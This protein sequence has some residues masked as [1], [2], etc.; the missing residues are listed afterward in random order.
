MLLDRIRLSADEG[1]VD[2]EIAG[3][4]QPAIG[5]NDVPCRQAHHVARHELLDGDGLLPPIA[6]D[7]SAEADRLPQRLD[8][9][10]RPQL[11]H[12]VED[13]AQENDGG[14]DEEARRLPGPRREAGCEEQDEN[15][16]VREAMQDLPPKGPSATA[17]RVIG[18]VLSEAAYHF[19]GCKP[20]SSR[21]KLCK[22]RLRRNAPGCHAS[23]HGSAS[24]LQARSAYLELFA[25]L[26][27]LLF[28]LPLMQRKACWLCRPYK[29]E[30]RRCVSHGCVGGQSEPVRARRSCR[31]PCGSFFST[32]PY[33][34][35][36]KCSSWG[37]ALPQSRR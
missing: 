6:N 15:K 27:G 5:R 37:S 25:P 3:R 20:A 12:D 9:V 29:H 26:E 28:R 21:S 10:L 23:G 32:V 1:L 14:D 11:L 2:E 34:C 8:S 36:A 4:Q 19:L 13:N 35:N 22:K 16:R 18:S 24:W 7:L 31:A 17:Q 30:P 33:M